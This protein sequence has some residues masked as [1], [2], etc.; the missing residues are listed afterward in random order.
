MNLLLRQNPAFRNLFFGRISS[1]FSDAIMFFS[2]LKWVEIQTGNSDSF[3]LFYIAFYMPVAFLTLPVGAWISKKTLQKVMIYSNAIQAITIVL[4]LIMMPFVA[5]EWIYVFLMILSVL[6]IFFVPA[7][8]SLFPYVVNEADRPKANSLLQL[9]FTAVKIAGQIFTAFAIKLAIS[10]HLLLIIS[11]ILMMMS[12]IFI[13]MVKPEIKDISNAD[14]R[15]WTLMKEGI[16]FI[17]RKPMLRSL[18]LFLTLG[19]FVISSID[20]LLIHFL[21]DYL[22]KGVENLSFIGT[23]SLIGITIGALCTPMWY[24]KTEE[25]KWLILP[26]FFMLSLSIGSL[27][28]ITN[29]IYVLPFFMLQGIALGC[30]NISLITYLQEV[31][32][33]SHYTRVFSL[34]Y[35]LSSSMALPGILLI[36]GLLSSIGFR[37]TIIMV[38]IILA[39]LG[40]AGIIS[41]PALKKDTMKSI[42]TAN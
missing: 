8:Q 17:I 34:Y 40:I 14:K 13:R 21:T 9:G 41:I 25:K 23:A 33:K 1:V 26:V 31:V 5:Y 42:E 7:N 36:G 30:F 2:L 35:M 22:G 11:V 39:I 20:L 15:Q 38:T 24:K 28:F 16:S 29:W 12:V 37:Q 6:G 32:S 10:P 19:M 3:T 4:F 27:Y 18:F